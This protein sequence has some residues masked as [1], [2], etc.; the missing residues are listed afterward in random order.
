[1]ILLE[2]GTKTGEKIQSGTTGSAVSQ[3]NTEMKKKIMEKYKLTESQFSE[4]VKMIGPMRA[5][6]AAAVAGAPITGKPT[7]ATTV[8]PKPKVAVTSKQRETEKLY[9]MGIDKKFRIWRKSKLDIQKAKWR[10]VKKGNNAGNISK[11]HFDR[12]NKLFYG[13]TSSGKLLKKSTESIGSNWIQL[14]LTNVK[15]VSSNDKHIYT[16]DTNN[17]IYRK[18]ISKIK[19]ED[20]SLTDTN[21]GWE[22]LKNNIKIKAIAF[23]NDIMHGI[24]DS[25][26]YKKQ[27]NDPNSSWIKIEGIRLLDIEFRT[28][29]LFGIGSDK[30]VYRKLKRSITSKMVNYESCCLLSFTFG[31]YSTA[32]GSGRPATQS[33]KTDVNKKPTAIKSKRATTKQSAGRQPAG[34]QASGRQPA[35]KQTSTR[36]PATKQTS[37]RQPATKQASTRP[38]TKE[39]ET[40]KPATRTRA[41]TKARTKEDETQPVTKTRTRTRTRTRKNKTQQPATRTRTRSR[42]RTR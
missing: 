19:T 8:K 26:L 34:R 9:L 30:K 6:S 25:S 31:L 24:D 41:R 16:I 13:I 10:K 11:I 29:Y 38:R 2:K 33:T 15:Y 7:E 36:Q 35:T 32:Q 20:V 23:D 42:R 14:G 37:T 28:G 5:R 12:N 17:K 4:L 27:S 1:I 22:Q 39:S 40:Q 3:I 18:E 21:N